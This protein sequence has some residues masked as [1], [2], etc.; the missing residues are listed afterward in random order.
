[1]VLF[2][3]CVWWSFDMTKL[4]Q[5]NPGFTKLDQL[6]LSYN[7]EYLKMGVRNIIMVTKGVQII[8]SNRSKR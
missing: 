5:W 6:V 7:R 2:G 3:F 8:S 1:M 4:I